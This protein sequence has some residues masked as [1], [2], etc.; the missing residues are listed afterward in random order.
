M[1][2]LSLIFAFILLITAAF[3]ISVFAADTF[4]IGTDNIESSEAN[5]T[6]WGEPIQLVDGNSASAGG[7]YNSV[8]SGWCGPNNAVATLVFD[9][10]YE[11]VSAAFYGWS[12]NNTGITVTLYDAEGNVTAEKKVLD[13]IYHDSGAAIDLEFS[14]VKAKSMTVKMGNNTKYDGNG[15]RIAEIALTA[16]HIHDYTEPVDDENEEYT[17]VDEDLAEALMNVIESDFDDEE[18]EE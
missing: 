13:W 17:F 18:D 12:N 3:A 16:L 15:F 2:K 14:N 5:A 7:W 11:I 6:T 9:K 8:T 10:E 1:K 4:V